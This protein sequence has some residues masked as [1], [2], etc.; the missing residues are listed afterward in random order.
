MTNMLDQIDVQ[1]RPW[2]YNPRVVELVESLR[3][4]QLAIDELRAEKESL[5]MLATLLSISYCKL[6]GINYKTNKTAPIN[7]EV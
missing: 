3:I 4:A 1:E 6:L 5:Q 2:L 7:P